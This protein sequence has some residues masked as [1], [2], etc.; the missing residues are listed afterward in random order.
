MPWL[1]VPAIT[2]KLYRKH[3]VQKLLDLQFLSCTYTGLKGS[4]LHTTVQ[5]FQSG[6]VCQEKYPEEGDSTLWTEVLYVS[7]R[8]PLTLCEASSGD[9]SLLL[10]LGSTYWD[11]NL[12]LEIKPRVAQSYVC[13]NSTT[14]IMTAGFSLNNLKNCMTSCFIGIINQLHY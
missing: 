3:H 5:K 6:F 13:T 14:P 4:T 9:A 7:C 8:W 12:P 11:G 2:T 10:P 1:C